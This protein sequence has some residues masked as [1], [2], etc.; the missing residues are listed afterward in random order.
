MVSKMDGKSVDAEDDADFE[1]FCVS[2]FMYLYLKQ[3]TKAMEYATKVLLHL[4]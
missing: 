1:E 4:K 3:N 2:G